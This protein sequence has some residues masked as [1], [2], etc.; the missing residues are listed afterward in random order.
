MS[1]NVL[2]QVSSCVDLSL[3]LDSLE[4]NFNFK[5]AIDLVTKGDI[6]RYMQNCLLEKSF[7]VSWSF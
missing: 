7:G 1:S 2:L 5:K 4:E 6:Y 3:N